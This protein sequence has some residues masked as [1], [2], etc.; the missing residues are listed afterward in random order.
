M[1]NGRCFKRN[2]GF[3]ENVNT[4]D[5][6]Q[7]P[8]LRVDVFKPSKKKQSPLVKNQGIEMEQEP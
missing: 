6:A 8:G 1:D 5:P 7:M 2:N 3:R 4:A